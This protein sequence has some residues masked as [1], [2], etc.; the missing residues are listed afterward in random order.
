LKLWMYFHL[1]LVSRWTPS[2]LYESGA[3]GNCGLGL[4]GVGPQIVV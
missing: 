2:I 3:G 4:F 1:C